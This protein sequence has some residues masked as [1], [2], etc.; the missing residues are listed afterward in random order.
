MA[1]FHN[2]GCGIKD[3]AFSGGRRD[4][5]ALCHAR[6]SEAD[7]MVQWRAA[8]PGQGSPACAHLS[9]TGSC[10]HLLPQQRA[11]LSRSKSQDSSSLLGEAV[12]ESGEPTAIMSKRPFVLGTGKRVLSE[13][14]EAGAGPSLWYQSLLWAVGLSLWSVG[15]AEGYPRCHLPPSQ[16]ESCC[17]HSHLPP[18][19]SPAVPVVSLPLPSSC[20]G[21]FNNIMYAKIICLYV[22]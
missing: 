6:S 21:C 8:F 18:A 19:A 7:Q 15:N 10:Q 12:V 11:Q 4:F 9:L 14:G 1:P 2:R 13:G 5:S 20:P 16:P 22:E 17:P 3:A